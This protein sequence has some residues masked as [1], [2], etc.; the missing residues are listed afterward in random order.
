[1][2][3]ASLID[4]SLTL[5]GLPMAD[6]VAA[7]NT[8]EKEVRQGGDRELAASIKALRK[9]SVAAAELNAVVRADPAAVEELLAA[10]ADLRDAQER[11]ASGGRS[12]MAALQARYR[13]TIQ[14]LA[15]TATDAHR[16]EIHAA[17]EA[18]ATDPELHPLIRTGTFAVAPRPTGSFGLAL[19][20]GTGVDMGAGAGVTTSGKP[21]SS[22]KKPQ[23]KKR[24][25]KQS[26]EPAAPAPSVPDLRLV[27]AAKKKA[28]AAKDRAIDAGRELTDSREALREVS[29][30]VDGLQA[31]LT[32]ARRER[33]AAEQAVAVAERELARSEKQVAAAQAA[34]RK[35]ELG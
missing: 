32:A 27:R 26:K 19:S 31:E 33:K 8:M 9:P 22:P 25:K 20:P 13:G 24:A 35:T 21:G 5:Y 2:P 1:M 23:S 6:F 28:E 4:A 30:R 29:D 17:L 16:I 3:V 12:D 7:R 34:L 14:A 11:I 18:A 10:V 15:D